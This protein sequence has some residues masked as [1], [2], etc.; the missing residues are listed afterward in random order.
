M[1][2]ENIS[3]STQRRGES[4]LPEPSGQIFSLKVC[5]TATC[6]ILQRFTASLF[7]ALIAANAVNATLSRQDPVN[8]VK[9]LHTNY[10]A[11]V[12][13]MNVVSKALKGLVAA[14]LHDGRPASTAFRIARIWCSLNL[15][16][17]IEASWCHSGSETSSFQCPCFKGGLQF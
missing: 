2:V 8:V 13:R 10:P 3:R 11:F 1:V 9:R 7:D 6:F 15:L 12:G 4:S 17:R 16:F 5:Y 14:V